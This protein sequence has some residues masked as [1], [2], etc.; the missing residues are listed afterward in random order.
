MTN[1]ATAAIPLCTLPNV[2]LR[3][4]ALFRPN[5]DKYSIVALC[6]PQHPQ[7]TQY[8][9]TRW[10]QAFI[11]I[12]AG[13]Y[14][15][16]PDYQPPV[17]QH[18]TY[19]EPIWDMLQ[20]KNAHVEFEL[21]TMRNHPAHRHSRFMFVGGDGLAIMRVNWTIAKNFP[22]YLYTEPAIIPV[23]GEH[24]HGTCHVAHMGWRPYS[25]CL[26]PIMSAIGHRELKADF[27]VS[28][29]NNY[30]FGL[31]ILI[32]GIAKYFIHLE[33]SGGPPL[34]LMVP[35]MAVCA[36]NIDLE[37]L[38]HFLLDFGFLYWDMRQSVR[39]NESKKIDLHCGDRVFLGRVTAASSVGARGARDTTAEPPPLHRCACRRPPC[40]GARSW[41]K[42]L[43]QACHWFA[44]SSLLQ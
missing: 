43:T 37:W 33:Q 30:D 9:V 11:A 2:D 1:W 6:H 39:G 4:V 35:F 3:T 21:K 14:F 19:R 13:T 24:P 17:A 38:S 16:R 25:P 18:L 29:F 41:S 27:S 5:F 42:R 34:A 28:D 36:V 44:L 8:R 7:L 22:R 40:Q 15:Q 23:Q 26:L 20:S 32:E 10:Q 12:K 31:C